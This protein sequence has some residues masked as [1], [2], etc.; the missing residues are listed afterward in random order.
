MGI[1]NTSIVKTTD[2][3]KSLIITIIEF[4]SDEEKEYIFNNIKEI[5]Y[6]KESSYTFKV[7]AIKLRDFFSSKSEEIKLGASAE[8]FLSC[9]LRENGFDQAYCFRNLEEGSI[10]KGFDGL[11][12]KDGEMWLLES[13][14]SS[15]GNVHKNKHQHTIKKAYDG[16]CDFIEGKGSNDPWE[17]AANHAKVF[18][19]STSL[20][21]RLERISADY[22]NENYALISDQ[23]FI[24]GST[25]VSED[26]NLIE[27]T[28]DKI[29]EYI[30]KHTPKKELVIT[31]NL[32]DI[33]ILINFIEERLK[34]G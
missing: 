10:K 11:Y 15:T 9:I 21:K 31:I 25:I 34:N 17:N 2:V 22:T 24:L 3:K 28:K 26:T 12:L 20:V 16:L 8:F 29:Y 18:G 5:S 32:A 23:N 7:V 4:L 13:K 19:S 33:E 27:S 1:L 6:G 14:S 30:E